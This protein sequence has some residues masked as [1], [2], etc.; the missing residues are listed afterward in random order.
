MNTEHKPSVSV[1]LTHFRNLCAVLIA[2]GEISNEEADLLMALGS[3]WGLNQTEMDSIMLAPGKMEYAVSADPGTRMDQLY[4]IVT[5]MLID[6]EI[7][8]NEMRLCKSMAQV[9][10]FPE[11]IVESLVALREYADQS[12][13]QPEQ[14]RERMIDLLKELEGHE[15]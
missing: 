7:H 9:L 2:D 12:E 10:G 6:G 11:R 3:R 4:E 8:P 13:L 5:M 1:R 14:V 15:Q